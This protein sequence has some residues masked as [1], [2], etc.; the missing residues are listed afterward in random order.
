MAILYMTVPYDLCSRNIHI[1]MMK[2]MNADKNEI[3]LNDIFD[4]KTLSIQFQSENNRI[5]SHKNNICIEML[6]YRDV[7]TSIKKKSTKKIHNQIRERERKW[8]DG[9]F[10]R[11]SKKPNRR[12]RHFCGNQTNVACFFLVRFVTYRLIHFCCILLSMRSMQPEKG[13]I[14][15]IDL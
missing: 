9:D 6:T 11:N 3:K 2:K 7:K 14:G 8:I 1:Q 15:H 10:E 13:N 4:R 5:F 12:R